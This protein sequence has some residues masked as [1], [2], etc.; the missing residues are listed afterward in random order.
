MNPGENKALTDT[1][2]GYTEEQVNQILEN[3]DFLIDENCELRREVLILRETLG[4]VRN[5]LRQELQSLESSE[6]E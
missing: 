5:W 4:K 2:I 6:T 1:K 3:A